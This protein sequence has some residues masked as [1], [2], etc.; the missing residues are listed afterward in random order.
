M[1]ISRDALS[2]CTPRGKVDCRGLPL[3][4]R[5]EEVVGMGGKG[6]LA[7]ECGLEA[8]QFLTFLLALCESDSTVHTQGG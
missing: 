7:G 3:S 6:A 5:A 2:L 4:Q 1:K 8:G